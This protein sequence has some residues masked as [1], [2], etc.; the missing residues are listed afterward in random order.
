MIQHAIDD[1]SIKQILVH[2]SSRF[3]R[4]KYKSAAI[5]GELQKYGVTVISVTSPYD[6]RTIDG[7]WRESI[8]ETMAMTSSMSLHFMLLKA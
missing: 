8:E 5:K 4:N 3:F 6:P 1:N 2:D 7:A